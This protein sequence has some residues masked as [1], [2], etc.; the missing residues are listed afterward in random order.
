V[1]LDGFQENSGVVVIAATNMADSLDAALT[2]PGRFDRKIKISAPDVREREEMI[3]YYLKDRATPDV[4]SELKTMSRVTT[5]FS[6]AEIANM[7]NT[8]ALAAVKA[9]LGKITLTQLRSAFDD[10]KMGPARPTLAVSEKTKLRTAFHEA[11]HALLCL[12]SD[13]DL[14][15]ATTIPRGDAL[16]HVYMMEKDEHSSTKREYINQIDVCVAGLLS[17]ALIYGEDQVSSGV[18]SDL[19]NATKVARN[20][21]TRFGMSE[22]GVM[23]NADKNWEQIS[24][25]TKDK[26]DTQVRAILEDSKNRVAA[27]L[28]NNEAQLRSLTNAM[29]QYETLDANE[30]KAAVEGRDVGAIVRKRREAEERLREREEER[31][32]VPDEVFVKP[33]GLVLK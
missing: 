17:E 27:Y 4:E 5:G 11:G 8:A 32:R 16:G 9:K 25:E 19:A 12:R 14:Y 23:V 31:Y 21:V 2:R 24:P 22:F 10:V 3:R 33:E 30:V 13:I 20:M 1:E 6:G 26:I 28:R 29:L 18:S 7:V 15:K